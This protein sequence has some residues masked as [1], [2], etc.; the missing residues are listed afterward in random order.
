MSFDGYDIRGINFFN[1]EYNKEFDNFLLNVIGYEK[2]SGYIDG[3][4]LAPYS[5]TSLGEY[6][7]K[8]FEDYFLKDKSYLSSVCPYLFKKINFLNN[9]GI[10]EIENEY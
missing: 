3:L 4:F 10:Q 8:G 5:I 2:L 7:A 6:F 9:S 1:E